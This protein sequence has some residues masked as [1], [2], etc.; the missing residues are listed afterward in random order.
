MQERPFSDV[1]FEKYLGEDKLMGSR[2]R[3]CGVL[4]MPPRPICTRCHAMDMNWEKMAV[5]GRLRAFTCIAV[6]PPFMTAQGF[7]RDNPYCT[8]VVELAEGT[9]LDARIEGVDAKNP[10][11]ITLGQPLRARFVHHA[12]APRHTTLVFQPC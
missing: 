6:G 7:N 10:A 1:S 4:Y 11:A 5:K 3:Q 9:R 12:D 2:C 8:G